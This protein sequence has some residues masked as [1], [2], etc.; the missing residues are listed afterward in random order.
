MTEES[1]TQTEREEAQEVRFDDKSNELDESL[2]IDL[3]GGAL[4]PSGSKS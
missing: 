1:F 4:D 3:Q 2:K